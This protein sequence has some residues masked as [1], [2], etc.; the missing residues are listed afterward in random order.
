MKCFASRFVAILLKLLA[1]L[2]A[3][4]GCSSQSA[5]PPPG[6]IHWQGSETGYKSSTAIDHHGKDGS[7][8][9]Q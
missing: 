4:L 1:A 3:C 6:E 8:E 5:G 7:A 2:T 9:G